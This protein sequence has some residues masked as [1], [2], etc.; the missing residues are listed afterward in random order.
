VAAILTPT[1][2]VVNQLLMAGPLVLLYEVS[3]IAVGLFARRPLTG[4][5]GKGEADSGVTTTAD[6]PPQD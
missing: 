2:D 4:F 6:N 3:I 1:P 5:P